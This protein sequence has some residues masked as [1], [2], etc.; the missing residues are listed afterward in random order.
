[1]ETHPHFVF[2]MR[3]RHIF[4][5]LGKKALFYTEPHADAKGLALYF[6]MSNGVDPNPEFCG[7]VDAAFFLTK[8]GEVL[9]RVKGERNETFFTHCRDFSMEFYNVEEKDW[10]GDWKKDQPPSM[11]RIKIDQ[12]ITSFLLPKIQQ[13]IPQYS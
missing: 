1:M 6:T 4:D 2:Q 8:D 13:P 7:E 11:V 12:K 3:M 9:L 10:V 5:H